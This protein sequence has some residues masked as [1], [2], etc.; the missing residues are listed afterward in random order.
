MRKPFYHDA[1]A[2]VGIETLTPNMEQQESVHDIIFNELTKGK[3]TNESKAKFIEIITELEARGAEG[4][5][6]GC[7]EIPLLIKQ[8]DIDIVALDSS[9]IHAEAALDYAL[10]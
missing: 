6:L 3:I 8:D 5:I 9:L 2:K 4:V 7:T 1:L 10:R